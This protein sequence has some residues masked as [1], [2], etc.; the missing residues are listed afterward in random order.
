MKRGAMLAL[1]LIYLVLAWVFRILW[2][3]VTGHDDYSVWHGG[4]DLG[5]YADEY[6]PD[7]SLDVRV[8]WPRWHRGQ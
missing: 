4:C 5:P 1:V 3:A 2:L 6:R 7:Y 8:F